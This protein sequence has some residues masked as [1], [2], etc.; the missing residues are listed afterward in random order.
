MDIVIGLGALAAL[1]LMVVWLA[2]KWLKG[3]R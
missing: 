3:G 2:G 1:F